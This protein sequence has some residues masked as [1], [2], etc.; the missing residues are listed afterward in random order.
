MNILEQL[1]AVNITKEEIINLIDNAEWT[2]NQYDQMTKSFEDALNA[3]D[4]LKDNKIVDIGVVDIDSIANTYDE[5]K[6][7]FTEKCELLR[8]SVEKL[9][10]LNEI[11]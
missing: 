5:Y 4:K 9:K 6:K 1:Q 2:V 11:L 3:F 7:E 10:K 8:T